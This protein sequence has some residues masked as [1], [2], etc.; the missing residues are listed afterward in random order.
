MEKIKTLLLAAGL[1]A[2]IASIAN[3]HPK[4]LIQIEGESVLRRNLRWLATQG[5]RD[6][7]INLHFKPEAIRAAAGNG[8]AFGLNIRYSDEPEILG[9]AGAVAHLA[10]EWTDTFLVVYGDSLLHIDLSCFLAFHKDKKSL[11]SIALF[12]RNVHPHTGI[13]GGTVE[14]A[15][16]GKITAFHEGATCPAGGDTQNRPIVNAGVYLIEPKIVRLIP[17]R[18]CDF[19]KEIFPGL[20]LE[21]IPLYG[22]FITGYCLGIDTPE[23]YARA[24]EL[25]HNK[26]VQL[27]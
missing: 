12:D 23:S 4:P 24:L 9:T 18:F 5:V 7:I 8:A 20:L 25:I 13:S 17:K 21:G 14:V 27:A 16:D 11:L 26:E 10:N 15:K 6:V 3:G 1:S 22:H 2:R 19:G